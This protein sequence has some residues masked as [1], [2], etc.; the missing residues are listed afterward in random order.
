MIF[1]Y[2]FS[3]AAKRLLIAAVGKNGWGGRIRTF[4]CGDQNPVPCRLA[5]PQ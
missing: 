2:E 3:K 5:T 1:E 4:E